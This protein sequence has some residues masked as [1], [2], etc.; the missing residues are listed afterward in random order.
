MNSQDSFKFAETHEWADQEDDGLVWVGIS[1]HAQEA[2]GDVMFFQAPKLGQEVVQGEAIATIESVKAASN[3]HAPISGNIAALNDEVEAA[4]ELINERP[5]GVWLFKIKPE[6]KDSLS[7]ELNQLMS[8]EQYES[9]P[10][11]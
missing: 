2:L 3:I 7:L 11:A 8:L 4:P 1:H 6:S 9:G 10:G 5:Y